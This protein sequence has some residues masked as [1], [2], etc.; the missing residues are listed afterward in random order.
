MNNHILLLEK[1]RIQYPHDPVENE[2]VWMMDKYNTLYT[3][4]TL[5]DGS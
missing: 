4:V 1:I 3:F 2:A 5:T